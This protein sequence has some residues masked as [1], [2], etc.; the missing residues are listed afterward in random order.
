M[1]S[2]IPHGGKERNYINKRYFFSPRN[3]PVS[4]ILSSHLQM[5]IMD[6]CMASQ[7]QTWIHAH[8]G[9]TAELQ[10]LCF[11]SSAFL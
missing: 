8:A 4:W 10:S 3:D 7:W 5:W 6:A 2:H 9:Q 1:V 11:P